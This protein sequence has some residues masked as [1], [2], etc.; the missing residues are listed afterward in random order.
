MKKDRQ[1]LSEFVSFLREYKVIALS[2]AFVMGAA[3][4]RLVK[5]MVNNLIMPFFNPILETSWS[6]SMISI[7]PFE[8]RFGAFFADALQFVILAFVV[9]FVVK[10]VMHL[11]QIPGKK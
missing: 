7:G 9:F 2:I 11:E 5:S 8:F 10:R 6:E 3:T 1:V 4:D